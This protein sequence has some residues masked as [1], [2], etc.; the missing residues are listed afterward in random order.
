MTALRN[1]NIQVA[2]YVY[3]FA[4]DGGAVG[5]IELQ[6]KQGKNALPEGAIVKGVYAKV[7]TQVTSAGSLTMSWGDGTDVDGY[8][9]TAKAVAALVAGAAFDG[10][11]DSGALFPDV[12]GASG[13]FAIQIAVAVATAGKMV[14]LVEYMMPSL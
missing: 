7:L 13:K 9:G 1:M 2:E 11:A 10:K 6:G 14:F 5:A 4:V 8:S 3:D 12:V